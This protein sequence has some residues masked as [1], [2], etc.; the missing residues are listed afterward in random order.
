MMND[1]PRP[2]PVSERAAKE[3]LYGCHVDMSSGEKPGGCVFDGGRRQDCV[4]AYVRASKWTCPYW[5]L[6]SDA[7]RT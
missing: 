5:R 2:A 7:R 4:E 6:R 1:N 3:H